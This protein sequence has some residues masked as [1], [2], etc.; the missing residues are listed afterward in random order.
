M[1]PCPS[2]G[3]EMKYMSQYNQWYCNQCKKYQ[4]PAQ[5]FQPHRPKRRMILIAIALMVVIMVILAAI[6]L[7]ILAGQDEDES[8]TVTM[9][10]KEFEEDV[11]P[12]AGGYK[13]LSSGDTLRIEDT[14]WYVVSE[15]DDDEEM[16]VTYFWFESSHAGEAWEEWY[17]FDN[18]QWEEYDFM[19][20]G[21]ITDDFSEGDDIVVTL[22][23]TTFDLMGTKIESFIERGDPMNNVL[24]QSAIKQA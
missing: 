9:S 15:Y 4:Q 20:R 17:D 18:D 13:S 5:Q 3:T 23:C 1:V 8:K 19:F 12:A 10:Y 14:V 22:H 2:C 21:D 24:P 16:Q 11:D 6:F 7:V